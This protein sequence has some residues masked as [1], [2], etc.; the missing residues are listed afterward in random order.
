MR[1]CISPGVGTREIARKLP[2]TT[3][4]DPLSVN[5]RLCLLIKG[6][7]I[8]LERN[9]EKPREKERERKR[10]LTLNKNEVKVESE[11]ELPLTRVT[12]RKFMF[13]ED[14]AQSQK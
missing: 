7:T 9:R 6:I 10:D 5:S 1:P 8:R 3:I 2:C 12:N 13:K 14:H 4:F 11:H